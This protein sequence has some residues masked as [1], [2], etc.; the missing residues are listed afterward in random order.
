MT[1]EGNSKAKALFQNSKLQWIRARFFDFV[2]CV[3][4]AQNDSIKNEIPHVALLIQCMDSPSQAVK[5]DGDK[6]K[7]RGAHT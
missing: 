1:H 6:T 2:D 4:F 5:L 7:K 3:N